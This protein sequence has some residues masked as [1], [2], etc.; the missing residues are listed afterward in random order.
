MPTVQSL[1]LL[2][3][4]LLLKPVFSIDQ[5]L[6][7]LLRTALRR[8]E[9]QRVASS[10]VKWQTL[11]EMNKS[12]RYAKQKFECAR[13]QQKLCFWRSLTAR[14]ITQRQVY[15]FNPFR[16]WGEICQQS[17]RKKAAAAAK[18]RAGGLRQAR[19][20]FNEW[21]N[22]TAFVSAACKQVG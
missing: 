17:R 21:F 6:E 12:M 19:V 8:R 20:I 4:L 15:L 13:L 7:V 2:L 10:F 5:H 16:C 1:L 22:H 14:T 11:T 18:A 9:S 3:L